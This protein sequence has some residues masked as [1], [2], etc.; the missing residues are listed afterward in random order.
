[1]AA[2]FE[3][4]TRGRAPLLDRIVRYTSGPLILVVVLGGVAFHVQRRN[5]ERDGLSKLAGASA[6]APNLLLIIWDTVRASNLSLFGYVR[7]TTPVLERLAKQSVV[8]E[9]AIASAPWT[10]PSHASFL[11]GAL[12]H[13]LEADWTSPLDRKTRTLAEFLR[14]HGYDTAGFVGNTYYC[15]EE[16]GLNRGFIHYED[17]K[18]TSFTQLITGSALIRAVYAHDGIRHALH[19]DE[20]P[21]RKNAQEINRDVLGWLRSN[22]GHPFFAFVNYFDAHAPY[23]PPAPFDTRFGAKRPG[24]NPLISEERAM[25]REELRTE[26]DQYDGAIAYLDHSLGQLLDSL[27]ARGILDNTI[28]VVA[29]DHGEQFGEHGLISHGNSLYLPLL[30]VP[31][32][33]RA[34]KL[35]PAGQRVPQWVSLRDVP[36]TLAELA[37]P[38]NRGAFPGRSLA[39]FWDGSPQGRPD[40]LLTE[41]SQSSGLPARYPVSRGDMRSVIAAPNQFIA[42]SNGTEEFYDLE[43]DKVETHNLIRSVGPALVNEFRAVLREA[44]VWN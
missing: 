36:A 29:A 30:H 31:L 16:S 25:S 44:Q 12:P 20:E 21:G 3:R 38:A 14:Q 13:Q 35:A 1:V 27:D 22:R 11:T 18:R 9:N 26:I 4:L 17:F 40:T 2:Q 7:P 19:L 39:R 41:V 43:A 34:P 6:N 5:A 10:L 23:L 33:I 24:R 37:S 15:S 42:N 28:V 32:L 8:F